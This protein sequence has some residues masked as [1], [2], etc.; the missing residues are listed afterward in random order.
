MDREKNCC[1]RDS[2]A[3][4]YIEECFER[5][6]WKYKNSEDVINQW[7]EDKRVFSE[8]AA[9]TGMDFQ[10]YSLHDRSHS[11]SILH[12]IEMV[13][14]HDRV[15]ALEASDLWLLLEAAY[16]HD[17]GM[18]IT[19]DKLC[20]LWE[21]DEFQKYIRDKLSQK[22]VDQRKTAFF[23]LK[24]DAAVHNSEEKFPSS[25]NFE[26]LEEEYDKVLEKKSWAIICE[27]YILFLYTDF[28]R[29]KHPELSQ[30]YI[31]EYGVEDQRKIP[32]RMYDVVASVAKLHGDDFDD[33]FKEVNYQENGFWA[34]HMHPQFAA[35]MLRL[36]DL[37][38]MDSNRFD[39]RMI[40]HIG[41]MPFESMLHYKKHKAITHLEYSE[42]AIQA[43]AKSDEFDVCKTTSK[44]FSWLDEEVQNLICSWNR[45][46]PDSLYGCRLNRCELK[47]YY[48][49][50]EFDAS[51]RTEFL[52][53]SDR[54]YDMLIG[55]NIYKSRLDF[56][57]EYLQNA[58]D[59]TKMRFWLQIK[60]RQDLWE[61]YTKE[62][63]TPYDIE[64][65]LFKYFTVKVDAFVD[66]DK[67]EIEIVFCD[68][69]IGMEEECV[70]S[71]SVIANDNWKKR[72]AYAKEMLDMPVW[73]KPTGGFGIGV[74]S[75]F[76][77]TD[78]VEFFTKTEQDTVGRKI[79]MES[80]RK[81]GCVSV[82]DAN[83]NDN[84][85]KEVGTEVR[86]RVRLM[87][88]F[89]EAIKDRRSYAKDIES[90]IYDSKK[91]PINILSI[92]ANYIRYTAS[93]SLFP[94]EVKCDQEV[95]RKVGMEWRKEEEE[96]SLKPVT[97]LD[98]ETDRERRV[99]YAVTAE[100]AYVWDI[101]KNALV[102]YRLRDKDKTE[103][104][105]YYKGIY[106]SEESIRSDDLD[107][108]SLIYCGSD[109]KNF[110][111]IN[112]DHFRQEKKDVFREDLKTYH[113][114]YVK[115][116][117]TFTKDFQICNVSNV[118]ALN[119]LVYYCL[120]LMDL[121]KGSYNIIRDMVQESIDIVK[122]NREIIEKYN[123]T[124]THLQHCIYPVRGVD[125]EIDKFL[126]QNALFNKEQLGIDKFID[127]VRKNPKIF[128]IGTGK[129][130]D[131]SF[132]SVNK[133]VKTVNSFL[134]KQIS[135]TRPEIEFPED[136]MCFE[137][138]QQERYFI[139]EEGICRILEAYTIKDKFMN[140]E[141]E[142]DFI[143]ELVCAQRYSGEEAAKN[144]SGG[145]NV[146]TIICDAVMKAKR[147]ELKSPIILSTAT[148]ND[149]FINDLFISEVDKELCVYS[150]DDKQ[151]VKAGELKPGMKFLIIPFTESMWSQIDEKN[152]IY[153]DITKE[154]YDQI[155]KQGNEL[156]F[157][158]EWVYTYQLSQPKI[159]RSKIRQRYE[160]L[161]DSLYREHIWKRTFY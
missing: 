115:L 149:D 78:K 118:M 124:K 94:I 64:Y 158:V 116:L 105:C 106:V 15:E 154:K 132:I 55:D 99:R 20:K 92:L 95:S 87:D 13:L 60:G 58:I 45:I 156:A 160:K 147:S 26:D 102:I 68:R 5:K 62:N 155:T 85:G 89:R 144:S 31:K 76:M 131:K 73:L 50:K 6:C 93:Y 22:F 49:G 71:L 88:F 9:T 150:L 44:W 84:K 117:S 74:Q 113:Y 141:E 24:L 151:L 38:D 127:D 52:A 41:N 134:G 104:R 122:P 47:I 100:T 54:V 59:A 53:D 152:M 23:Y 107:Q 48:K 32:Y 25:E 40:E 145:K 126:V 19:F 83:E 4:T 128:Y 67:K 111:T 97:V 66:W 63:I 148:I 27:R 56:I 61:T 157:L 159:K 120:K 125:T 12:S 137:I 10:H 42:N 37:L 8:L 109:V 7:R 96:V 112:R 90:E 103:H 129:D 86:V 2:Q 130:R 138:A 121:E 135:E 21:S 43:I 77:I 34:E 139:A 57:R 81:G 36:G 70:R 142:S 133:V 11:I 101:S 35:A 140:I 65:S 46:V 30:I 51:K 17:L 146:I 39:V 72:T 108:I 75:A 3:D 16:C 28:V 1:L 110:L 161:L 123:D 91:V 79:C 14:G 143:M 136:E 114:M 153:G 80:N 33:L 98:D 119:V 29:S 18:A 69:G 82:Y